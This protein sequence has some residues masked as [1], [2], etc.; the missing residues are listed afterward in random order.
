MTYAFPPIPE[1]IQWHEGMLL[2]PQHFQQSQ[3]RTDSLA[4]WHALA[5]APLAWGVRHL[6][7]D[8]GLLANGLLRILA[9][10]AVMPDGT[11]VWHDANCAEHGLLELDLAEHSA[12]LD[13]APQEI[14]LTLPRARVMNRPGA[15][16]RFSSVSPSFR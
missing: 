10:D 12:A 6:E 4:G 14:W 13:E 11:A 5:A 15:P 3:A 8:T 16:S 7:V 9:L 2:A 1:R